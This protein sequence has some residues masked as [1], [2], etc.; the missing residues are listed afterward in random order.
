LDF[1]PVVGDAALEEVVPSDVILFFVCGGKEVDVW[2]WKVDFL[3]V[4]PCCKA[5][6][7]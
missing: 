1:D 3:M 7:E 6:D 5:V 2:F 4:S